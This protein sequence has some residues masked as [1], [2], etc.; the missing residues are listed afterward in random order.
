MGVHVQQNTQ[1]SLKRDI[2]AFF[3]S[4]KEAL[5]EA[6]EILFSVGRPLIIGEACNTAY[7]IMNS[8]YLEDSHSYTF[9]K[10]YLGDL[11]AEL[12]IYI[13][14]AIQLY[15]DIDNFQLIKAH[16]RSG[17]VSLM[18]YD[19]WD[20]DEPLLF[21]RIK[22]KLGELDIDFFDYSGKFEPVPL[23]NKKLYL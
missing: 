8:G 12:R 21:E 20:K 18:R 22:I 11:P 5:N 7:E 16:I 6:K 10:Q 17:K 14:C 2:K 1:E 19:D 13:G 3:S 9:Q 15:G 23:I 4:Y